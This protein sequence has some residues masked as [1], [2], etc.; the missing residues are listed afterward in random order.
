MHQSPRF[1]ACRFNTA[2][3]VSDILMPIIKS[4]QTAVAFIQFIQ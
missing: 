3:H 1:I 4:L 2:Q